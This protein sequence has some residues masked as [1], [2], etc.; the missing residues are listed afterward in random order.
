MVNNEKRYLEDSLSEKDNQIMALKRK[1]KTLQDDKKEN[2]SL[3]E[4]EN[5]N[6]IEKEN[7]SLNNSDNKKV[8]VKNDS[9]SNSY[10]KN[11]KQPNNN[12]DKLNNSKIGTIKRSNNELLKSTSDLKTNSEIKKYIPDRHKIVDE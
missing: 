9:N 5:K 7:K 10:S 8:V 12:S 11:K 6:L 2:K 1:L 4:K 3:I